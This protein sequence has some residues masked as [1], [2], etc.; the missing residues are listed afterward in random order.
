ME[1]LL[2]HPVLRSITITP[3]TVYYRKEKAE[4]I[5]PIPKNGSSTIQQA[6]SRNMYS[7]GPITESVKH[8]D[9][10]VTTFARDPVSRYYSAISTIFGEEYLLDSRPLKYVTKVMFVDEH[11]IPQYYHIMNLLRYLSDDTT[12]S[13][14]NITDIGTMFD[15]SMHVNKKDPA[16]KDKFRD[17]LY[18]LHLNFDDQIRQAYA[19]DSII[20][21]EFTVNNPMTK[22]DI[23]TRFKKEHEF[24]NKNSLQL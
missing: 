17:A 5:F 11:T 4:F 8:N 1:N 24:F 6:Y 20:Y 3:P 13:F 16:V 14:M 12:I 7:V 9:Y 22:K 2:Y 18:K 19:L 15:T 10:K 23:I 21:D